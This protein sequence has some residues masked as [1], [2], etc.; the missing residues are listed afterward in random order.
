MKKLLLILLFCPA[1]MAT[2]V[3][4]AWEDN[5]GQVV[6]GY[7]IFNRDY[8]KPYSTPL[9]TTVEHGCTV[10]VSNDRQTA[11]V[12]RCFVYGPY[13][14]QGNRSV[15]WSNDSNEVVWTPPVVKPSPPRNLAIRILVAIGRFFK[16]LFG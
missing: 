13:D 2:D 8:Q 15:E 7:A 6:D 11:F 14:L 10:T 12:A 4:L 9:C 16:G 1:L 3:K 5:S